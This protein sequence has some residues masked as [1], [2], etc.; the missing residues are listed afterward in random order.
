[1]A[2]AVISEPSARADESR[3][4]PAIDQ[5]LVSARILVVED[6]HLVALDIELRLEQMGHV[7][8]AVSSGEDALKLATETHFDLVLMDIKLGGT[9]DG[10]DAA[11]AIRDTRD[12]PIIYLTAY[13]DNQTLQRARMTEPYGY[14]VKPFHERELKAAIEMALQR[15]RN[16]VRRWEQQELHKFLA[17]ASSR[18]TETLDYRAVA[19]G[20]AELLVPRYADWCTIWLEETADLAPRFAYTHPNHEM[21]P[22]ADVE[23]PLIE[24][25]LR[26]GRAELVHQIADEQWLSDALGVHNMVT[27]RACGA[28]SLM[29]VPIIARDQI[30]GA[31]VLVA[32]RTRPRYGA[33]NDLLIAEDFGHRLGVALDN[34]LLYRKSEQAVR[35]RDD[36][37]AIVSHDLRSPLSTILMQAELVS[38]TPE[39]Q[40]AGK[41]ITRCAQRMNRLIDDLLDA[42]SLNAGRLRLDRNVH[43]VGAILL[44]AV[45]MFRPQAEARSIQLVAEFP[46]EP[47]YISCDRDRIG[48]ALSNLIG[49]ALKFTER[50]GNVSVRAERLQ[51][52]IRIEVRDT[53]HGI[54]P[55]DVLRLFE[56]FWRARPQRNGAGLGLYIAGGIVAAHGSTLEVETVVGHGS[57]FFFVLPEAPPPSD[58]VLPEC[59]SDD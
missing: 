47:A 48:Q 2:A 15:H 14:L 52:R 20:A 36:V 4:D 10:I 21:D 18:M 32:G 58:H 35:M 53:G 50:G 8:V 24:S 46:E 56:P 12:V 13:A 43:S 30:L 29:C 51:E 44:E 28:Q 11:R 27:L 34:A 49:N 17:D 41:R 22:S 42:S 5:P 54:P 23:P 1:M 38:M 31:I 33:A 55:D 9:L 6:E 26:N 37:L 59:G 7:A 45:E 39:L 19:Q 16:D 25:V 40:K 57:S 3:S